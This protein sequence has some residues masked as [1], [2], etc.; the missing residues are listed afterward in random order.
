M[1]K[2][3]S[4]ER[5]EFTDA[6]RR[7]DRAR[8]IVLLFSLLF[9]AVAYWA[10]RDILYHRL[11]HGYAQRL[12]NKLGSAAIETIRAVSVDGQGDI[13]LHDAE[14]YTHH[15]GV[16]RLFFRT[17]RLR[18]SLDGIPLRDEK[19]KVMRIDLFQPEIFVRRETGGEWNVQWAFVQAPR[20]PEEAPVEAPKDD[21]WKDYLRPDE[22]FPRNGVHIHDGI[23]NVTFVG[24]SGKEVTWRI[25]AVHAA[26]TRVD[27]R[28]LVHPFRG[29]FYGG[30]MTGDIEVP[31][32][33]PFT[34]RKLTVDV[35]DADVSKMTEGAPFITHPATGRFNGV[36]A[37]TFDESKAGRPIASGH[38]EVTDGDLWEVPAFSGIIHLLTLT[39]VSDRKIDS[40]VLEFTAGEGE[41][42]VDKMHFLGYPVSLFGDGVCSL[43]GDWMEIVFVPRLGKDDWNSIIPVIG[44]PIDL[45]SN[46]FKGALTPVVLKGSFDKPEVSVE[47]FHFLKP[48]VKQL[49]E[50]KSPR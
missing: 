49:I 29:E 23:I 45:L 14:A 9:L 44:A 43:T 8:W 33:R 12:Y 32:V 40:A 19:L 38:C 30:K 42:R 15:G 34:V 10:A 37:L 17:E 6:R 48:S 16:R 28:L 31:K 20:G 36:L 21:P 5:A 3:R 18:L 22:G 46:I 39:K 50:E 13:T 4:F 25:T 1:A 7:D 24:P 41:I 2:A 27:G 47:P 11:V 35:V 26:L